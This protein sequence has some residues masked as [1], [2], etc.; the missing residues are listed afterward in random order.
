MNALISFQAADGAALRAIEIDGEPW[1]V[2]K[3]AATALGYRNTPE[4]IRE[5]VDAEDKQSV[6]LG[7]PGR[8]PVLVSE[9]GLYALI[10]GS[11]K[12]EARAF[13]RWVTR[14]VLP[15]IR[16]R[17]AYM[18]QAVAEAVIEDPTVAL[19]LA[20]AQKDDELANHKRQ[21]ELHTYNGLR[22][23]TFDWERSAV[24][25]VP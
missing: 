17:G 1:F 25:S 7:L 23:T 21:I 5:H 20:L 22:H 3:D 8:A 12:A 13:K 2:A 24:T 4:A 9:A 15:A 16:K 11:K 6:S 10:F 14:E 18:T 19:R